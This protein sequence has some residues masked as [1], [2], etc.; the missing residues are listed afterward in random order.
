[1][2]ADLSREQFLLLL[3]P[4]CR[5]LGLSADFVEN[6]TVVEEVGKVEVGARVFEILQQVVVVQF[7]RVSRK[8]LPQVG[9]QV[10]ACTC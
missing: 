8:A 1:M 7:V 4:E 9:F 6:V 5:N 10:Q 3:L 2:T